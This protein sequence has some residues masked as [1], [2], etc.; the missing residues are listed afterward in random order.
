[1]KKIS[2]FVLLFLIFSGYAQ[3]SRRCLFIGNSY[4]YTNDL[5][6]TIKTLALD[7]GD[8]LLYSSSVPGGAT[9]QSHTLNQNTMALIN[10]G[11]WNEVVLQEQS[12]FPAF[13]I[14]QVESQ[15]FPYAEQLCNA[16]R[17][18]N[19]SANIV[20]YMTWGRKFGDE[21]NCGSYPPLCTY[22]GMDSLL[23]A[24]YTL[25]AENNS[26]AL[27]PVGRVW[28]TLRYLYPELD[29]YSSDNSHPSLCGTYAAAVTFYSILF[30]KSPD[31]I[32]NNL[33]LLPEVAQ[34]IREVVKT[35]VYDSLDFWYRYAEITDQLKTVQ[36]ADFQ[37]FPN[38]TENIF[39][40]VW[41]DRM[42]NVLISIYD[43]K[44]HLLQSRKEN[45]HFISEFS[46]KNYADGLYLVEIK[47]EKGVIARKKI[48]KISK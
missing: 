34:N 19:P 37:L 45:G 6:Q 24:R 8:T 16:I 40:L 33:S 20:F 4:V 26:C 3:N 31:C 5:P 36:T 14:S 10:Q 38:P 29:L 23:Y 15:C 17:A 41:A 18:K 47:D 25:M 27:S 44:G 48:V 2:F 43:L 35:V 46:M 42:E 32:Q 30:K 11:D 1:M 22:E 28:H 12:Q 9:F 21:V 39:S 7:C 13:P